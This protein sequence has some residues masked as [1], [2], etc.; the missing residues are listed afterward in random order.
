MRSAKPFVTKRWNLSTSP[1]A[2]T[3]ALKEWSTTGANGARRLATTYRGA[4][5]VSSSGSLRPMLSL[6]ASAG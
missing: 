6:F 5:L 2:V 3:C 1:P 4:C